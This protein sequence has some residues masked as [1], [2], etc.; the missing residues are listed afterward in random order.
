MSIRVTHILKTTNPLRNTI[1]LWGLFCAFSAGMHAQENLKS[2]QPI[3]VLDTTAMRIGEQIELSISVAIEP[4]DLVTFPE[5]PLAFLPL[6]LVQ[7]KAIDSLEYQGKL[8]LL[9]KYAL[10]QFD[11]GSYLLPPQKVLVNNQL[12]LTDSLRIEVGNVAVDTLVQ[13]LYDIKPLAQVEKIATYDWLWQLLFVILGLGALLLAYLRL[14]KKRKLKAENLALPAYDKALLALDNLEKTQYLLKEEYKEYYSVLT[15]I[16]RNYLEEEVHIA[17]LESTT[18]QLI[19]KLALLTD[20]GTLTLEANTIAQFK[21]I[22]QTA[23]L[24]KFAK[25]KPEIGVAE[26]DRKRLKE[27]VV[28]TKEAIAPPSEEELA[29]LAATAAAKKA[30][31]LAKTRKRK[32]TASVLVLSGLLLAVIGYFG[33]KNVWDTALRN[34]NKILLEKDWIKSEYGVPAVVIETPDVLTRDTT[35]LLTQGTISQQKF[36]YT[37]PKGVLYV[38]LETK[39]YAH[40]E[41]PDFKVLTEAGLQELEGLGA[42][43]IITKQENF[44]AQEGVKGTKT[45]GTADFKL[46]GD[47]NMT[48]EDYILLYFGGKGYVQSIS[49]RWID[50]DPYAA[51]ISEKI[52]RSIAFEKIPENKK[53]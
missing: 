19:E 11:S 48:K 27:V 6:E 15:D 33:P 44:E 32:I 3:G 38:V 16:V 10:T 1:L 26:Q 22:L 49:M 46:A 45:F 7:N 12:Y 17:A 23:D 13:N 43:N 41:E 8:R 24:V 36:Y 21:E 20:A 52:M 29:A 25:S 40:E 18:D 4:T 2:Y 14:Q 35:T 53:P 31:A 9:K 34:P 37:H 30:T 28:K 47:N 39:K 50:G 51:E 5:D 42:K